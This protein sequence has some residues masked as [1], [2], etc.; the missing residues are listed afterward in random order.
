MYYVNSVLLLLLLLLLLQLFFQSSPYASIEK[1]IIYINETIQNHTKY[2]KNITK[3]TTHNKTNT[4][5][6]TYTH[7]HILQNPHI[8][9]T[10]HYKKS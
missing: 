8:H 2:K 1:Q 10:T 7:T 6:H 4:Y 5:T 3:A 9:T